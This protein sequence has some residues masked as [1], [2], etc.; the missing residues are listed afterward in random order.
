M[1]WD[2]KS[3]SGVTQLSFFEPGAKMNSDYYIKKILKPF[4]R[5]DVKILYPNGDYI[6]HQDSAPSHSSKKAVKYLQD[7]KVTYITPEQ[8]MPNSPDAA[9]CD[10]F[11]WRYL[12]NRLKHHEVKSINRLKNALQAEFKKISQEMINRALKSWPK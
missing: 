1:V 5:K 6:V 7:N 8:W 4:L 2:G 3:S 10:Y 12:K 11:L 9:P